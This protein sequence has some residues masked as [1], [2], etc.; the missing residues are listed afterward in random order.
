MNLHTFNR[1]STRYQLSAV[2]YN[3]NLHRYVGD[4]SLD[5]GIYVASDVIVAYIKVLQLNK[6]NLKRLKLLTNTDF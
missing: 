5:Y 6:E 3:N 1:I 2:I 4:T